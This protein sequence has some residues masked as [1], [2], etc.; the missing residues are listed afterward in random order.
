[1]NKCL[2]VLTGGFFLLS[3]VQAFA[4]ADNGEALGINEIVVTGQRREQSKLQHAGNISVLDK[5]ALDDTGHHHVQQLFSQIAGAWIVRGSGQEHLT[6]IRSPV[7]SGAGS[8][9]GFLMLEDGIPVRPSGFCNVNQM[10]EL[11]TEQAAGVEVIR[12]PGNALYGSN[13]LHGVVNVLLPEPQSAAMQWSA[14]YGANDFLR[15][16]AASPFAADDDSS[17]YLSALFTDDGGFRDQAS[18]KEHKLHL[19]RVGQLAGGD[20]TLAFT[21][22]DLDQ[23]TAGY[24]YGE[25]AYRDRAL[26]RQNFN[27]D[28]FRRAESQR[29]YASWRKALTAGELEVRPFVRRSEMDFLHHFAPGTPLENNGQT[30]AGV[31]AMLRFGSGSV[32]S[33]AGLDVEWADAWLD[34]FQEDPAQGSAFV[35]ATRPQGQH[36]DYRVEQFSIAPYLQTDWAISDQMTLGAGVR[37]EYT[38][39]DYNNQMLDGNS[40]DDGTPCPIACLYTRPAD[41]SDS[42]TNVAPKLSL[43]YH[44]SE[45]VTIFTSLSRGFRAPQMT[46]LYRL[47]S[48]QLV[49]DLESEQLDSFELGWRTEQARWRGELVGY[50]MKKRDS[51]FRDAEGFNVSGAKTRHRGVEASLRWQWSEHWSASVNASYARHSYGFTHTPP[52]GEQFIKGN[53]VDAAPRLTGSAS[54]RHRLNEAIS[55]ELQWTYLDEYFLDVE[56]QRS[57]SGHDLLDLRLFWQLNEKLRLALRVNNLADSKYADRADFAFGNYR[58]FPG[59]GREM[60]VELQYSN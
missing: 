36:Y 16:K 59:R 60:F 55:A 53:D 48:G 26:S 49:S 21:A 4:A 39:Y 46:E 45:Q 25:E 43:N 56:N 1:M 32:Q 7:L 12:G 6:A 33:T 18:Y 52:R 15:L 30:S 42:Y 5:Q 31:I 35:V 19:K 57:Y 38:R 14:E 17:W 10:F 50:V 58:Y 13:A 24:I 8:C 37:M 54:L 3:G 44:W 27:P 47:Q 23:Q 41:R 29:L 28:A 34:Q 51:V 9:G 20:L 2:S 11:Y 40:R 22:S